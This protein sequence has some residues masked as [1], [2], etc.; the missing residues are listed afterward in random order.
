MKKIL[1]VLSSHKDME[2]TDSKTG[3]WIGEFSDPYYEFLDA[4]YSVTLASPKGGEPPVDPLSRTTENITAS[5]RR[6]QDDEKAQQQFR[7][8]NL[9]REVNAREFDAVFYPGGHGPMWDL[10]EDE[11]SIRLIESFVA[12]GKT[13]KRI[14]TPAIDALAS[15]HWPGNV[16]ELENTIERA[17]VL[18]QNDDFTEDLLP[19]NIRMFAQQRRGHAHALLRLIRRELHGRPHHGNWPEYR[20]CHLLDDAACG[21]LRVGDRVSIKPHASPVLHAINYLLGRLDRR[22]LTTLREFARAETLRESRPR[23]AGRA[24]AA[25]AVRTLV[26]LIEPAEIAA[27]SAWFVEHLGPD[28]PLHFTAFHPD[29][30]LKDSPPTPHARGGKAHGADSTAGRRCGRAA[31]SVAAWSHGSGTSPSYGARTTMM[32]SCPSARSCT[33]NGRGAEGSTFATTLS[34][35]SRSMQGCGVASTCRSSARRTPS[36]VGSTTRTTSSHA[37]RPK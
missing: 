11:N 8:T 2:N 26:R 35:T 17:V 36:A 7:A 4:G 3:V 34:S 10:A 23:L 28:V 32:L 13:I 37:P 5:N 31:A 1:M 24:D 22:Y 33:V 30:R 19:L 12:A 9:L 16:R 14:S 29:Y 15:Y 18:S 25:K 6:F 21:D 20:V 27:L